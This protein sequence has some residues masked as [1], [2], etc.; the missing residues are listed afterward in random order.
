MGRMKATYKRLG[1]LLL[2]V[3]GLLAGCGEEITT[4]RLPLGAARNFLYH[5]QHGELD[6]AL[7]YWAPDY[8]PTDAREQTGA[9]IARLRGVEV[10][11]QKGEA[12]RQT[13]GTMD[14]TVRGRLR[15][16][17]GP[18]QEDQ[19][20]LRARLMERGPGW[21]VTSFTLVCCP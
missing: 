21:R 14:V 9:A 15:G 7:T 2:V 16:G 18:W 6:D 4:T 13:D 5:L 12:A 19:M 3:G 11:Y 8:T 1:L 10:E 20:I 17:T